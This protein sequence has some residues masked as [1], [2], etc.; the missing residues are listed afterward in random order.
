MP[1]LLPF[2]TLRGKLVFFACLATLPAFMFVIY[3]ASNER[4]ASFQRTQK[5]SRYVAESA[6]REHAAQ[7]FGAK[8]LLNTLASQKPQ[9]MTASDLPLLLPALLGSFPQFANIGAVAPEGE[10]VYSAVAPS[11]HINMAQIPAIQ[12]ARQTD[13]V[14]MGSYLVGLIVGR[15]ILIMARALRDRA[16]QLQLILFVAL[17]LKWLDQLAKQAGLPD[18][19]DL[20]IVDQGGTILASSLDISTRAAGRQVL[21]GMTDILQTPEQ[22][23]HCQTADGVVRL[24]VARPLAGLPGLWAVVATPRDKIEAA[25]NAIFIR[26]VLVLALLTVLAILSSL[27]ATDLSVL[28]DIRALARA[29]R[30]FGSGELQVRAPLP[31]PQGEIRNLIQSF[32][33]MADTLATQKQQ[34]LLTQERLRALTHQLQHAREEE[35]ARIAQELHDELGQELSVLRLELERL[36]RRAQDGI[37]SQGMPLWTA[38]LEEFG[39]HIDA[40]VRLVRR[41]SSELRPGVLDRL[42]LS[43]GL[44]W[45]L[46]Q[47]ARRTGIRTR[48]TVTGIEACGNSER[49]TALFRITQEALSNI[50][51]HSRAGEVTAHLHCDPQEVVL[52]IRDDGTG[53]NPGEELSA[54]S[55]G[56][57]GM[58]ERARRLAGTLM[59]HS[60]PG[61]G[62]ELVVRIPAGPSA[63]VTATDTATVAAAVPAIPGSPLDCQLFPVSSR[64]DGRAQGER[65]G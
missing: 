9:G 59:I 44:E 41:I 56:L 12:K 57:L 2:Q 37:Q 8:R 4:A 36:I 5:M 27:I 54:P 26:D 30:R 7:V 51:R 11:R 13:E 10:L 53:F 43:A 34:T 23:T 38:A 3:V 20:L 22:L 60:A 33:T 61:C 31:R 6:S 19:S 55:L 28:K 14:A 50:A 49:A 32:N 15:P 21:Q 64:Q 63:E 58:Q 16:G 35:S 62:T 1:R 42:G 18:D 29:T 17:D 65:T 25:A 24:A 47:Y 46:D 48:F 52:T 39:E 40:A 45:L